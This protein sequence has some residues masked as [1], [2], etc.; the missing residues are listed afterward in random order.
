MIRM[1][2]YQ[3]GE[4]YMISVIN[5]RV[6]STVFCSYLEVRSMCWQAV[7]AFIESAIIG[8]IAKLWLPGLYV[9][10]I[11]KLCNFNLC[12]STRAFAALDTI[13]EWH[14]HVS[15]LVGGRER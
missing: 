8:D 13:D 11:V 2:V 9:G 5:R 7:Y 14:S 10:S 4:V 12:M 15:T 3:N 6:S 1:R